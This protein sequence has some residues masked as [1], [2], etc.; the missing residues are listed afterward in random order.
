[1]PIGDA[2]EVGT[3]KSSM[4]IGSAGGE[5][6]VCVAW[7]SREMPDGWS[8]AFCLRNL[9]RP[10][11]QTEGGRES[12]IDGRKLRLTAFAP[13]LS[14]SGSWP[15]FATSGFPSAPGSACAFSD[16]CRSSRPARPEDLVAASRSGRPARPGWHCSA[17]P[18]RRRGSGPPCGPGCRSVRYPAWLGY[19]HLS[20]YGRCV[21][22]RV[23]GCG[24]MRRRKRRT[25]DCRWRMTVVGKWRKPD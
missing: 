24:A 18:G 15:S 21:G 3:T 25:I 4:F 2:S 6:E 22:W 16:D 8:C 11:H 13:P 10:S 14:F 5:L 17:S 23:G 7:R 1:M 19:R 20:R 9:R 12:A